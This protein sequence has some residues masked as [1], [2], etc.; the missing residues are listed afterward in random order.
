MDTPSQYSRQH[1]ICR[2]HT[3]LT[4]EWGC[5]RQTFIHLFQTKR[6]YGCPRYWRRTRNRRRVSALKSELC[7]IGFSFT[8]SV[9]CWLAGWLLLMSCCVE[10]LYEHGRL[11]YSAACN[12]LKWRLMSVLIWAGANFCFKCSKKMKRR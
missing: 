11:G 12:S 2:L 1:Q 8:L 7:V 10:C 4:F 9:C 5:R 6:I 3:F